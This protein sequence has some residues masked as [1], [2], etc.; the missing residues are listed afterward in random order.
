M[1]IIFS[2][3]SSLLSAVLFLLSSF[4]VGT[5]ANHIDEALNIYLGFALLS[6]SITNIDSYVLN[7]VLAALTC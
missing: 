3:L 5:I 6:F 7:T 1:A 4:L 2:N